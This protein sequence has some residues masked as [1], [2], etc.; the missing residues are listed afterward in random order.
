MGGVE[1]AMHRQPA[2]HHEAHGGGEVLFV[3]EVITSVWVVAQARNWIPVAEL[4]DC[5]SQHHGKVGGFG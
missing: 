5:H 1:A 2:Y 3:G 4:R